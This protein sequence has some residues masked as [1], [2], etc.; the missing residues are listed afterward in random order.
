[1]V[2]S[3]KDRAFVVEQLIENG[4]SPITQ[5]AFCSRFTF[6]G[7]DLVSRKES[8]YLWMSNFWQIGSALKCKTQDRWRITTYS[9]NP[10]AVKDSVHQ[11]PRR[12]ER[13]QT[14]GLCLSS[15]SVRRILYWYFK[16][17]FEG[18]LRR[19]YLSVNKPQALHQRPL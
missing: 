17:C 13:K 16:T 2:L 10:A 7:R 3:D 1:M 11:S 19:Y 12:S 14:L 18:S 5:S 6:G 15:R 9:Q 8:I 4:R